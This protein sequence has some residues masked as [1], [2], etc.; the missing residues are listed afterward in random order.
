MLKNPSWTSR[1]QESIKKERKKGLFYFLYEDDYTAMFA[2]PTSLVALKLLFQGHT[3]RI[4]IT[5]L[6]ITWCFY[7]F[8]FV[9]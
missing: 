4:Y 7:S 8:V 6:V 3:K 9:P 5:N 2:N 1:S